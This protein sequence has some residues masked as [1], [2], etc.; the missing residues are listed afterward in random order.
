MTRLLCRNHVK[1][2]THW[3]AVFDSHASRHGSAGLELLHLWRDVNDP[4]QVWFIFQVENIPQAIAFMS[5]PESAKA[6]VE[7]GVIDGEYHFLV[8]NSPATS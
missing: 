6:G 7:A 4:N 1:D 3:K 2:F 8:E 5:T